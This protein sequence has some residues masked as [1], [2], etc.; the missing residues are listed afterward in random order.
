MVGRSPQHVRP[1]TAVEI[2]SN[3]DILRGTCIARY[4]LQDAS[5][6]REVVEAVDSVLHQALVHGTEGTALAAPAPYSPVRHAISAASCRLSVLSHYSSQVTEAVLHQCGYNLETINIVQLCCVQRLQDLNNAEL[7]MQGKHLH[8]I[9]DNFDSLCRLKERLLGKRTA[10]VIRQEL[11]NQWHNDSET[12]LDQDS[13]QAFKLHLCDWTPNGVR[14]AVAADPA[15]HMLTEVS[16][17]D[18]LRVENVDT[19]M[20]GLSWR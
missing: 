12:E 1:L 20:D 11:Q 17:A 2:V 14:G 4:G 10:E 9:L 16:L 13:S 8:I 18:L 6:R 3:W 7:D 19:V 5:Q 15:M